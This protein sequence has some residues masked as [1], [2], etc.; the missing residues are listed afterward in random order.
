MSLSKMVWELK[1][2]SPMT[3]KITKDEYFNFITLLE[4]VL[5]CSRP[6]FFFCANHSESSFD[7]M[8][9]LW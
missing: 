5:L 9:F 7:A 6:A 3:A 8:F 4:Q 2:M 1:K